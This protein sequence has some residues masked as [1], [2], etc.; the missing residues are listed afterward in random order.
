MSLI[1]AL[2]LELLKFFV[3]GGGGLKLPPGG[4]GFKACSHGT[5]C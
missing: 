2:V 4:I 3:G 5:S 1:S